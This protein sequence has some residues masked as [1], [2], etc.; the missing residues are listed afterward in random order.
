MKMLKDFGCLTIIY[1]TSTF[2]I[3]LLMLVFDFTQW[4]RYVTSVCLAVL[5]WF[6][7][8]LDNWKSLRD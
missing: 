4:Q 7:Y 2:H 6:L 8:E 1:F 3:W 5:I